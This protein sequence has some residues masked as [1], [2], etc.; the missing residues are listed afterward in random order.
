MPH[1][2]LFVSRCHHFSPVIYFIAISVS[3]P[4]SPPSPP[5][6][7]P[8]PPPSLQCLSSFFTCALPPPLATRFLFLLHPLIYPAAHRAYEHLARNSPPH[9]ATQF[10]SP[11]PSGDFI[12]RFCLRLV[13]TPSHSQSSS[14][15]ALR[16]LFPSRCPVPTAFRR[17]RR[18]RERKEEEKEKKRGGGGGGGRREGGEEGETRDRARSRD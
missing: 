9:N 17:R 13:L 11:H 14:L 10:H 7:P 3:L 12:I 2:P 8:P 16:C 6:P 1:R 5:P 4:P 15:P 18:V